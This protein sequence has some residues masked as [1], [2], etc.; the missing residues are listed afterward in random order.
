MPHPWFVRRLLP[1]R[2][3]AVVPIV[4]L[5][6]AGAAAAQGTGTVRGTVL[7]SV[8]GRPIGGIQV[9]VAGT[10]RGALTDANG[11]YQLAGLPAGRATLVVRRIGYSSVE[12]AVTVAAGE[13]VT[14][15][16][17][18][19]P[20]ATTL[21]AIV[22]VGYGTNERTQV[23]SAIASIDSSVFSRAPVAAIDNALQGRVPG[24]QVVQN[25]GEPGS[26]VSVRGRGRA[27]RTRR[28]SRRSTPTRSRR[29]TC[30]RTPRPRR[31]TARAARTASSSSPRSAA[32]RAGR[33]SR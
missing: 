23:S 9:A 16:F 14:A 21:S 10:T 2:A 22:S 33:A 28:P 6:T 25:S 32:R 13:T 31:S 1:A 11:V 20:V 17:R 19:V 30:S 5:L 29:S 18:L 15:D 4:F 27:A 12:R 8:A 7:D 3:L 24:V 26:A